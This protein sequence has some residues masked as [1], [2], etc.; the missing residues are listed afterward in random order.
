MIPHQS[1]RVAHL[2]EW[3]PRYITSHVGCLASREKRRIADIIDALLP[4]SARLRSR[5]DELQSLPVDRIDGVSDP[6]SLDFDAGGT[7]AEECWA[8]WTIQM[9]H[10][11][12]ARNGCAEIGELKAIYVNTEIL[13]YPCGSM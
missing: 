6:A 13:G 10:V 4:L 1:S 3:L 7:V 11:G 12:V 2:F 9:E 5:V 8:V